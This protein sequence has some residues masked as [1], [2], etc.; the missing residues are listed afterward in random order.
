[1]VELPSGTRSAQDAAAAIGC[2]VSQIA[3]S[4]VFRTIRDQQPVLVLA[5]GCH[6]INETLVTRLL[7]EAVEKAD[8]AYVQETTGFSIGGVPPL[9]L[10]RTMRTLIDE[11]LL[12]LDELWAPAG[13]PCAVFRL[14]PVH[15]LDLAQATTCHIG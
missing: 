15:L 13:D 11:D 12:Q 1:M 6:R 10:T 7:G 4:V 9:G 14:E 2:M 8:A 5:S 3:K